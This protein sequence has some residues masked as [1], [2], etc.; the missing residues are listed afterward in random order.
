VNTTKIKKLKICNLSSQRRTICNFQRKGFTLIEI[1]VVVVIIGILLAIV[2]PRLIG[3]TDDAR[4]VKAKAQIKNFETALK[5]FKMDN[6]FYPSTEQGLEALVTEPAS[7]KIPRNY[8]KGGYLEKKKITLDP[9]GN[10]YVYISPGLQGDFD[11][12]SYGADGQPGGEEYDT[13]IT[14]WDI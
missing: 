3:R 12:I 10:Q 2:A 4:V 14:N 5:L 9:W 1:M 7:G 8:Q 6:A 13:D 11:I